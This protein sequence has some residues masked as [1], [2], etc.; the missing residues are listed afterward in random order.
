MES[1]KAYIC[2]MSFDVLKPYQFLI[3]E[4]SL[5]GGFS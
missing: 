1:E 3:P 5:Y 2:Y 4:W